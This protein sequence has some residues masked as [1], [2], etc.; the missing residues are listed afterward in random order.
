MAFDLKS[1]TK[2]KAIKA[3]RIMIYATHGIGKSTWAA[4]A[5]NPVFICTEDGLGSIDT[6]AFPLATSSQ[7]VF[8]AIG[9]LL[10]DG[11]D[12]ETVVLDSADWLE[13]VMMAEIEKK[14]SASE[15]AYGK[16]ALLLAD[17]WRDVLA[18]LN[19]LRLS[20]NMAVIITA[21]TEIRRFESPETD[22]YD[23]Y[24]P[25]LQSRSSAVVQEWADAV[26]FAN[27]KTRVLKT[28]GEGFEKDHR[29][30][31]IGSPEPVIYTSETPAFLAKNRYSLPPQIPMPK[32]GGWNVFANLI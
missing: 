9:T 28:E 30:G 20:R 24:Q 19:E 8:E 13:S 16:G 26:F 32:V 22:P 23:R 15:L 27:Y 2:G 14:H 25:K 1:I 3:P 29:R 6:A 17:A 11:H 5:P 4:S 21:H 18:G 7:H 31:I 12:F 10:S